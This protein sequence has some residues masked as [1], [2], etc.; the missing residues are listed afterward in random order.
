MARMN[1]VRA[2][3]AIA[4]LAGF[5]IVIWCCTLW[6]GWAITLAVVMII[7]PDLA[8]I[9]AFAGAGLLKPHRV[10]LYNYL[11]MLLAPAI[12]FVIGAAA[13]FF[14]GGFDSGFWALGLAGFTW[15][16][17]IAM[18]RAFGFGLRAPDGSIIP[19]G[20]S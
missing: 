1:A 8:L 9:G 12:L 10:P 20:G 6:G 11:H 5:G 2:L 16:V 14:T 4:A 3:W 18:D 17:H 15:L 13:F 19:V 7:F